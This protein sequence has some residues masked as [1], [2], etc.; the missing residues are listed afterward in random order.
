MRAVLRCCVALAAAAGAPA[1]SAQEPTP[2]VTTPFGSAAPNFIS[3]LMRDASSIA[4]GDGAV[5]AFATLAA[6]PGSTATI[7]FGAPVDRL[8]VRLAEA[9]LTPVPVDAQTY[10]VALPTDLVH[11]SPLKI[12]YGYRRGTAT[13]D[14]NTELE[15]IAPGPSIASTALR[16]KGG[17]VSVRV[18]CPAPM[19][20]RCEGSVTLRMLA[21]SRLV[22]RLP[23][24][25]LAPGT[26]R[27]VT[28]ELDAA[29]RR[30]LARDHVK[31]LWAL[32]E[33]PGRTTV[34]A[35]LPLRSV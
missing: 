5:L 1:A 18:T 9:P 25:R 23:F 14:V 28:A 10:A 29:A 21:G 6:T 2:V 27:T 32:L 31:L 7:G 3:S 19:R 8:S 22:A 4:I 20:R 33:V 15:V 30:R 11:P 26:S 17:R 34:K 16:R 24:E 35:A 13:V 12:D